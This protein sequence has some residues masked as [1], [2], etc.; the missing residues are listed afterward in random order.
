MYRKMLPN[1]PFTSQLNNGRKL[2]SAIFL[3]K[4]YAV[5]KTD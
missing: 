3:A 4:H 5:I 2:D 1:I